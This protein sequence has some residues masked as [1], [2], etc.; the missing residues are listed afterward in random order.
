MKKVMLLIA[1]VLCVPGCSWFWTNGEKKIVG[2]GNPL[3]EIREVGSFNEIELYGQGVLIFTPGDQNLLTIEADDNLLPFITSKVH[4]N[5]LRIKVQDGA[6]L[7]PKSLIK[8]YVT[9]ESVKEIELHGSAQLQTEAITRE[10]F[11]IEATGEAKVDAIVNV[12]KL[13]ITGTGAT[14]FNVSGAAE[15]QKLSFTG[16][17]IYNAGDVV[18]EKVDVEAAGSAR[19]TINVQ[20]ELKAN[21][22]GAVFVGY[23]GEPMLSI[24]QS[25]AASISKVG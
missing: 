11:E 25:G 18:S 15:Q 3:Q 20:K 2:S 8:Y 19:V 12:K 6:F 13:K 16:A 1:I 4:G 9:A 5:D 14:K 7:Q 23:K 17:A 10:S 21:I 24:K 22:S